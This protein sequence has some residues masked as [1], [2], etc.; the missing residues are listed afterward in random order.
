MSRDVSPEICG[1]C[2]VEEPC[3]CPEWVDS[4]AKPAPNH[5]GCG[6]LGGFDDMDGYRV[7]QMSVSDASR[8]IAD[9]VRPTFGELADLLF[10]VV[11]VA[12]RGDGEVLTPPRV[13]A[14]WD[15]C[16]LLAVMGRLRPTG[17]NGSWATVHRDEWPDTAAADPTCA[18][19][20]R[21]RIEAGRMDARL[22]AAREAIRVLLGDAGLDG[23]GDL[24]TADGRSVV[25][26]VRRG[27][28]ADVSDETDKAEMLAALAALD[29]EGETENA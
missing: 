3:G 1:W 13:Q 6:Y 4:L 9:F 17:D 8:L 21:L 24:T 12:C 19:C 23:L 22:D 10:D 20:S 29:A 15:T 11:V 2:G 27:M 28:G 26:I 14:L 16:D 25:D 18:E 5:D 7:E